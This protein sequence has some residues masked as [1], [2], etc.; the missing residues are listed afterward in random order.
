MYN[1]I[2]VVRG[3]DIISNN[4]SIQ[5]S[6]QS[7]IAIDKTV[8]VYLSPDFIQ[9]VDV[10]NQHTIDYKKLSK[11]TVLNVRTGEVKTITSNKSE[12]RSIDSIRKTFSKLSLLINC[13]YFGHRS[14]CFISFSYAHIISGYEEL[15]RDIKNLW[16]RFQRRNK[17][18]IPFRC[19]VLIEYQR[20]GNPHLHLLLKRL[21]NCTLTTEYVNSLFSWTKGTID[22]Q[23]LYDA[24][25]LAEYLNPFIVSKKREQLKFY[26]QGQQIY[27]CYGQFVRPQKIKMTAKEALRLV[28]ENQ[29]VEYQSKAYL[30]LNDDVIVNKITKKYFK[31]GVKQNEK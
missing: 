15:K 19:L 10:E 28:D 5:S 23:R 24:N 2:Y 20:N 21:D 13:N 18:R 12:K 29:L 26:K 8:T 27:R 30:V 14:E 16:A 25:G 1:A 9:V 3:G 7:D 11:N 17:E 6:S 31:K 22:V 4:I